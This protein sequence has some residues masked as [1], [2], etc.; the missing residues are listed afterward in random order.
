MLGYG[1]AIQPE[2]QQTVIA[3]ILH[4]IQE[5]MQYQMAAKIEKVVNE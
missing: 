3:C 5:G 1:S 4:D 2:T